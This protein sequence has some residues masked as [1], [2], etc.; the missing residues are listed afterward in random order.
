MKQRHPHLLQ[1]TSAY[2]LTY[3]AFVSI[4]S[5]FPRSSLLT[6][7]STKSLKEKH[8]NPSTNTES[9]LLSPRCQNRRLPEHKKTNP[10]AQPI[11]R[12]LIAS[13]QETGSFNGQKPR[14][15]WKRCSITAPSER[16]GQREVEWWG[17][18]G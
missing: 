16:S 5:T 2:R 3:Q 6:L 4:C 11:T 14:R 1:V 12:G 7:S 8:Q 9:S 10:V 13:I 15:D 17:W 18:K